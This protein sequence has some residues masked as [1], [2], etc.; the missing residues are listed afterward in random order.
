MILRGV[1]TLSD[2]EYEFGMSLTNYR[3]DPFVE[4]V[5][6]MADGEYSHVSSSLIKQV[7]SYGGAE[8]LERFVPPELIAPIIDKMREQRERRTS[9]SRIEAHRNVES[10]ATPLESAPAP[11][12]VP[13]PGPPPWVRWMVALLLRMGLGV[14]LLNGGLLGFLSARRGGRPPALPGPP[15]SDRR[16]WRARFE[17]DLL[18]PFVQIAIGLA[19]ILGFFTVI[20][21]V[22]AGFLIVSG[23]IFQFLAILSNSGTTV[24][25]DLPMQVLV[26]TGSINLLLLVAAVLWLT[27]ME[28]TP[29]SLDAL[30]F[31]HRRLRSARP[32]AHPATA[33]P[34][35]ARRCPTHPRPRSAPFAG[36]E[37]VA[38]PLLDAQPPRVQLLVELV[39]GFPGELGARVAQPALEL[40]VLDV[41]PRVDDRGVDVD[42]L[43]GLFQVA[44]VSPRR[45]GSTPA[46]LARS[47]SG[48]EM[49][50]QQLRKRSSPF[51]V[52]KQPEVIDLVPDPE[53]LD[54][55]DLGR[56]AHRVAD[57]GPDRV[58]GV[59]SG[60]EPEP[61]VGL[62]PGVP[63]WP[64]RRRRTGC[65][66]R[67]GSPARPVR[68]SASRRPARR[69]GRPTPRRRRRDDAAWPCG[70]RLRGYRAARR[71]PRPRARRA[72]RSGWSS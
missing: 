5:F 39:E 23:P 58:V 32:S 60:A 55:D 56:V 29:W 65:G 12:A 9:E 2:M 37:Q 7:A 44:G 38:G 35:D 69:C 48:Q 13:L 43:E 25:A 41:A 71:R 50:R 4:T 21:A 72:D 27:P 31:A 18:V 70:D 67:P 47:G 6:L 15:C 33:P 14:S 49:F 62:S 30:I 64:C 26:T 19:L 24:S 53:L 28:G 17:N 1:R 22:L 40:V 34:D 54:V 45:R 36:N 42:G 11:A 10:S 8:A 51:P 59:G 63:A 61:H 3:L 57:A 66:T 46:R 68:C 20:A 16:P 52:L